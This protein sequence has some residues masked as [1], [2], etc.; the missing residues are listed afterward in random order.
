MPV[1]GESHER[2]VHAVQ[3]QLD[4][5]EDRDDVALDKESQHAAHKQDSAQSQVVEK[6][7][8]QRSLPD[9]TN[10]RVSRSAVSVALGFAIDS[11][12]LAS[13][14]APMMAIK[15]RIEVT[16]NGSRKS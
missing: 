15:I 14:T 1:S 11:G 6:R 7:N 16:S 2:Q 3:H 13:T 12:L 5:H 9:A 8:H 10:S 4:R